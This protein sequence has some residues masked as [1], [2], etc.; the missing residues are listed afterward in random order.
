MAGRL[1]LDA[2]F[3]WSRANF[4]RSESTKFPVF[5]PVS[6]EFPAE[7][8]SLQTATTAKTQNLYYRLL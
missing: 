6:R 1:A 4:R 3:P 8:G 7:K 2:G 5:F